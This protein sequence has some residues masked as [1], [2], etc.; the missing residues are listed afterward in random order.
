MKQGTETIVSQFPACDLCRAQGKY[1]EARY[2]GRT[3][4]GSWAYMCDRHWASE[5]APIGTGQG[6]RLVLPDPNGRTATM[7][8]SDWMRRVN[9]VLIHRVGLTADDLE[10]FP[11]RD[12]YE[13]GMSPAEAA[14]ECLEN[15][16]TYSM[17][18]GME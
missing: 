11:S 16:D 9:R 13:A 18:G 8:Y 7:P 5:G 12:C 1:S 10:D 3:S 6:Q 2:D 14:Q 17:F 4:I 15:S